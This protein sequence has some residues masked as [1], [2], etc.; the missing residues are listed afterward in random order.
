MQARCLPPPPRTTHHT[1]ARGL[2][3]AGLRSTPPPQ[4][5][6]VSKRLR[7]DHRGRSGDMQTPTRAG[8]TA[9]HTR[10]TRRAP[11]RAAAAGPPRPTN[12]AA[13]SSISCWRPPTPASAALA[14]RDSAQPRLCTARPRKH[15]LPRPPPGP[16]GAPPHTAATRRRPRPPTAACVGV[17]RSSVGAPR[18]GVLRTVAAT[19]ARAACS[20]GVTPTACAHRAVP[21]P[22]WPLP[23]PP[24]RQT[25]PRRSPHL[26]A[27]N[28]FVPAGK[29]AAAAAVARGPPT[30]AA[31]VC[32]PVVLPLHRTDRPS[33]S[34]SR[35]PPPTTPRR[36][37]P[38][39]SHFPPFFPTPPHQPR[40]PQPSPR[41][42]PSPR[43][44][45]LLCP[46]PSAPE[47][48]AL[49][50]SRHRCL[51]DGLSSLV[52][53]A[54]LDA[55]AGFAHAHALPPTS[56]APGAVS[57]PLSSPPTSQWVLRPVPAT[58]SSSSAQT[59]AAAFAQIPAT[60]TAAPSSG[61]AS[62]VSPRTPRPPSAASSS[63]AAKDPNYNRKNHS[64][65]VLC[66][67]CVWGRGG[68]HSINLPFI[69]PSHVTT[70]N[71]LPPLPPP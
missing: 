43:P 5:S 31:V 23:A 10:R 3:V 2:S 69:N 44:A 53:A 49:P 59:A 65:G 71:Y 15:T 17:L 1:A 41:S 56:S 28:G 35:R 48:T 40:L 16:R 34:P 8:A 33:A 70:N 54:A 64:L 25:G 11:R 12:T 7:W 66:D 18:R 58:P 51:M 39:A 4:L 55:N 21:V 24:R 32:A 50:R 14:A 30:M 67:K 60:P 52:Q 6:F 61:A 68:G 46:P 36:Q 20:A 42:S 26:G 45:R 47:A 57:P 38:A 37:L 19:Q 63:A 29:A 62:G 22:A 13:G 27:Q 9:P